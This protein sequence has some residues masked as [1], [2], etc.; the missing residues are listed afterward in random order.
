MSA[1]PQPAQSSDLRAAAYAVLDRWNS[2]KWEWV[3]QCPTADLMHALRRALESQPAQEPTGWRFCAVSD[4]DVRVYAPDGE[5][6]LVRPSGSKGDFITFAH[7]M[8]TA[9]A[10]PTQA[11]APLVAE[12][13]LLT[14]GAIARC[15]VSISDPMA[16]GRMGSNCGT[17][18]EEFARAV[19]AEVRAAL[20]RVGK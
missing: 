9:L 7:R 2:P 14:S 20:A 16:W 8:V 6:W 1:A 18:A 15:M 3:Q 5:T 10:A 11:A 13:P 4:G 12:L 17:L 19:E